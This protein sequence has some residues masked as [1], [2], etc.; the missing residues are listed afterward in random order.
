MSA[1][2]DR[3]QSHVD[4][5]LVEDRDLR[6]AAVYVDL[7]LRT[8]EGTAREAADK[9]VSSTRWCTTTIRYRPSSMG[10]RCTATSAG[11]P[12]IC[13]TRPTT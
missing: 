13:P 11:A 1:Y 6:A 2:P 8:L 7:S 10:P 12:R 4:E 9:T 3:L 5:G